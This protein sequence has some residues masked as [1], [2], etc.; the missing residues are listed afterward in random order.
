MRK[1]VSL[2]LA[3]AMV[4]ALV[5]TM[6]DDAYTL[7]IYWV[8][9]GDNEA[10]RAGVEAAVNAYIEPL[11]NAKVSYHIVSWGDWNDKAINA[12]QSGEKMDL[13]FT[14]DWEGYGVE[15]SG[16]LLLPLDDLLEQYGQG[17]KE[18]LPQTFLDGVKVNG[19]LYGIPTNKE[20]CVPEGFIINKTAAEAIGWDVVADDPSIKT[21]A[22]LEP[23]LEKYKEMF[24]EKYP[25]LMDG[26]AGRWADE[27]W[28]PDWAG[29]ASN[30]IAM[31]MAAQED[32]TFDETIYS[33]FETPEQEEHIRLMYSWGQKGYISPDAA[34]SSF[35]YNGTFGRGDFLVFS[36]PLKGNGIKAAEMYQANKTAEFECVEITMQP[37]YV[38]TT[39]AGGSMFAIP[40]T[41]QNPEAAMK[42]LNLM[43][44]DATLVNLMLF[45]AE[46]QNYTK[47]DDVTVEVIGDANWYGVHG[48]AWTVGNTLLQYVTV[49]EDPQ[50]NALLQ[51][52]ADDA[53]ATASLGFRFVK[54][55]VAN[56]IADVD[57]VIAEYANPLMCG[58]VDPDGPQGIEAMKKALQDAKIGEII[59]EI[60]RQYDAWKAAQ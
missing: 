34:L 12:L 14:A 38:V 51:S 22:D 35:D 29:M 18:T 27:P 7:D 1:L 4:L 33:I 8:G 37:K 54:D 53:V 20:L 26:Q 2:L 49:G 25:Y 39:H 24:P 50:K 30:S 32:G 57:S 44:S 36:Q 23:W 47:V 28:C 42:Y 45:G 13:I 60:Q 59:E 10:V 31:K 5:P 43:H 3:L 21:T 6:A 41:C 15:V 11:I 52:Y 19:V 55:N 58:Q 17:I 56:Q 9:N 46:G 40:V 16:E 48:G